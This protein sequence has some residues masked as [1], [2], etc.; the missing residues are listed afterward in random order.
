MS[1][2]ALAA[3][4][5]RGH[6]ITRNTAF[7]FL[8]QLTGAAFTGFLTIFLA[9]KL[10]T[11]GYGVLSLAL[12]I[13]GLALLPS[14]FGV[15]NSV[16]RFVAEHRHDV[17]RIEQLVADG[18]RLKLVASV[19]IAG[20][21]IALAGPIADGYGLPGLVWPI[22]GV[23]I[24][25]FAQNLMMLGVVF[26]PIGRLDLQLWTALTES[27]VETTA[28]VALVLAGA[29]AT[30]AAFGRAIGYLAGALATIYLLARSIGPAIVPR[31]Y[32][33]GPDARRIAGYASVLLVIDG[34]YT[35][36][37]QVDVLIVG[38][39][40]SASAVGIFG[41][42]MRLITF[43]AYPG[44]AVSSAVAP[45]LAR[46]SPDGPNVAAFMTALRLLLVV[47]A[48]ITAFV[49]GWAGL[50]SKVVL[51]S[52]YAESATVLRALAPF[53][54]LSGFG[55]IVSV[56]ANYLGEAARRVPVAIATALLNLVID[57]VLVPKVGVV[58]GA[59]GTDVAFGLYAPAHLLICQ[60]SLQLDLRPT[61]LTFVRG[62]LAGAALT[63]A[64]LLFGDSPS[65]LWRLPA[66][67]LTGL[68]A[69]AL[70]LLATR[71]LTVAEARL[72]LARVNP[73]GW[74][75]RRSRADEKTVR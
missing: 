22:R 54:F 18:F 72:L 37:T 39:Y 26:A 59:I 1:R 47:Q 68:G 33:F 29:G 70:V 9:R 11:N 16:G 6:S 75:A 20:L 12:G 65:Q 19:V 28:C 50:L 38:A 24:A 4:G 48:A 31:S 17:A 55:T 5:A 43:L 60:R 67:A 32:R 66:G 58:G 36:F 42:P 40:L 69:F 15:S 51:G 13:A 56:G 14:D 63:G 23:A 57:L 10:G 53:V 73:A 61:A 27:A 25:L 3:D 44:L 46:G 49:L 41:A 52:G 62:L 74:L 8:A 34:A 7:A 35:A 64:L 30:G 21:L 71:E 2:P 45:R